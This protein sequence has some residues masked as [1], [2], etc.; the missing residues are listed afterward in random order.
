M[1]APLRSFLRARRGFSL[2]ELIISVL[3]IGVM[4]G[5]GA[6]GVSSQVGKMRGQGEG[7]RLLANLRFTREL[8]R[9][10]ATNWANGYGLFFWTNQTS[11]TC[12]QYS[13]VAMTDEV[14]PDSPFNIV[15]PFW[16]EGVPSGNSGALIA[17]VTLG[18]MQPVDFQKMSAGELSHGMQIIF[19]S[20]EPGVPDYAPTL[21]PRYPKRAQKKRY[22]TDRVV[23]WAPGYQSSN[24]PA[25]PQEYGV[26]LP[27]TRNGKHAYNRIYI[28][29]PSDSSKGLD[30]KYN[31]PDNNPNKPVQLPIRIHIH[32]G[33]GIARMMTKYERR[34]DGTW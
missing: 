6:M 15:L 14:R 5:S 28:L 22:S 2:L 16:S 11:G 18:E 25:W 12:L 23:F 29:S 1:R 24:S 26:T 20:D 32:P 19:Q 10:K 8:A 7:D 17:P 13:A 9:G 33:T 21:L 30:T 34:D 27:Q 3:I 4:M 31:N